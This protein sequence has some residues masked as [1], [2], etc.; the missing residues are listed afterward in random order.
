MGQ[1]VNNTIDKVNIIPKS[2]PGAGGQAIRRK[3]ASA[4]V[5]LV[6]GR[7]WTDLDGTKRPQNQDNVITIA[8]TPVALKATDSGS[9]VIFNSATSLIANLPP[10][11]VGL[12]FYF[13]VK[14][15][16]GSGVGHLIHSS[17]A[18]KTFGKGFTEAVGKGAVNT[19]A[20][21]AKGDAFEVSSDGT[22]WFGTSIAGTWAREA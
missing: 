18:S 20:T 6:D 1:S 2:G 4:G 15:A 12:Y 3:S 13:Y 22:D 16:A 14:I 11:Q 10:P 5:N 8:T 21:G 9:L 19:Q 17:A 7:V